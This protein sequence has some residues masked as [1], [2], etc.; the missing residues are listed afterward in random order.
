MPTALLIGN[1]I[2]GTSVVAPA[3]IL[4]E[5]S[6][7]LN[8]S[9]R[10]ASYL[11]AIGAVVLCIGSPLMS[12][13]TSSLDR[14]LTMAGSMFI[15]AA[16][17][18]ASAFVTTFAELFAIRMV[19]L[20]A[21]AFFTPQAAS[22]VGIAAVPEK[23]A[24]AIAYVFIGWSFAIA[25]GV[26][27]ATALASR[28][29]WPAAYLGIGAAASVSFLLLMVA[30]PAHFKTPPIDLKAWSAL[31]RSRTILTLLLITAIVACAQYMILTFIA[32]LLVLLG[33][34]DADG[35]SI[36]IALFGITGIVGSVVAARIVGP[37]GPFITSLIFGGV[38]AVGMGVWSAGAEI[39]AAMLV[40]VLIWGFGFTAINS[41]QQARLVLAAPALSAGAV[42]LNTSVLYVGQAVGSM[43]GGVL[44]EQGHFVPIGYLA[45]A[46]MLVALG[47]LLTTKP[48]KDVGAEA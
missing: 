17:H 34:T 47:V 13:L 46:V 2:I 27:I 8:V 23:R 25:L 42:A 9:I 19:M 3:G 36:A 12:W 29:G 22:L 33:N 35:I 5:L 43:V 37:V 21:A 28:F 26:P 40:G 41:L 48:A 15:I 16:A 18:I 32:P 11:I 39:Y 30:V 38:I 4:N 31:F 7:G 20:L 10:D 6:S 1:F 44:F 24:G 14:R 45:T